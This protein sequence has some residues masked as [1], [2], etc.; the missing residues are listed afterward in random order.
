M[1]IW[2]VCVSVKL[3]FYLHSTWFSTSKGSEYF[4]ALRATMYIKSIH[5]N[6]SFFVMPSSQ[7]FHYKLTCPWRLLY[8]YLIFTWVGLLSALWTDRRLAGWLLVIYFVPTF[9]TLILNFC[10]LFFCTK[11]ESWWKSFLGAKVSVLLYTIVFVFYLFVS[12][13]CWSRLLFGYILGSVGIFE[14]ACRIFTQSCISWI[15]E[16][17]LYFSKTFVVKFQ[18][19]YLTWVCI[20]TEGFFP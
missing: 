11:S 14:L 13:W 12:H 20:S 7:S 3:I 19:N 1:S 8:M 6:V 2:L 4:C 15:T 9:S 18:G 10:V 17:F 5:N 16:I